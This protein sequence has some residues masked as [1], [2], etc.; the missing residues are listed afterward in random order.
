MC[1]ESLRSS[2]RI[3]RVSDFKEMWE[4]MRREMVDS[5]REVWLCRLGEVILRV[6]VL[7][8]YSGGD[9]G[10]MEDNLAGKDGNGREKERGIYHKKKKE[11]DKF[12]R[13][14]NQYLSISS[15]SER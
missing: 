6:S 5:T 14:M 7:R 1:M 4:K 8:M 13:K 9:S 11:N 2:D 15:P 3:N 12:G 10:C